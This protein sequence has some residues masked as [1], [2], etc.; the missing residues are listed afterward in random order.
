[1]DRLLEMEIKGTKPKRFESLPS[2]EEREPIESV[3]PNLSNLNTPSTVNN[4]MNDA[5]EMK[6]F[7]SGNGFY[8]LKGTVLYNI[9]FLD[10]GL[11]I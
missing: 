5:G 3:F 1:M 9:R 10:L 7:D 2:L 4:R 8:N 11:Q 6:V